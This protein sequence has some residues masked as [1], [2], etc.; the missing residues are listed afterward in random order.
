M[1]RR[2][3]KSTE[4][5]KTQ[6]ADRSGDLGE[7]FVA[8]WLKRQGWIVLAQRWH[9]RWGEVDLIMGQSQRGTT[10]PGAIAFIEV[11]T[12]SDHNW[13]EDGKLSITPRKQAK[14]WKTAQLFLVEHPTLAEL[15]CRFDVAL[16]QCEKLS[17]VVDLAQVDGE[18]SAIV[19]GYRL[20]LREYLPNAFIVD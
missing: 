7:L 4:S 13:D 2:A 18:T 14:L 6:S 12:R 15:P 19:R 1:P 8:Q 3:N 5:E 11:K 9:S 17:G 16:V 20:T 10:Q